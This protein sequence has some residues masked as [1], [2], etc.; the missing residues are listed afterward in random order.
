MVD[1]LVVEI[2]INSSFVKGVFSLLMA[3]LLCTFVYFTS[4][5]IGTVVVPFLMFPPADLMSI[6]GLITMLIGVCLWI[7]K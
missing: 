7:V 2:G 1:Q 6:V 5:F 3:I 4:M